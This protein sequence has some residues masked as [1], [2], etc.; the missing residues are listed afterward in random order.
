MIHHVSVGTNDVARARRFYDAVLPIIGLTP[1]HGSE[2]AVDY[3]SGHTV[4]SIETPLDGQPA[5]VGNG[6]HV[7]FSAEDRAMVD[8]FYEAALAHGGTSDGPPGVRREYDDHY[9]GAFVRDP[10]GNK[11]EAVTFMAK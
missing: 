11:I 10:D 9:Y 6:S 2:T 4:F 5:S 7:A 8:A 1:F 3:G